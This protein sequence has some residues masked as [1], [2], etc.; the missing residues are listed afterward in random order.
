MTGIKDIDLN[1][2][3]MISD[4]VI[5]H[6]ESKPYHS[7]CVNCAAVRDN[8]ASARDKCPLI[9]PNSVTVNAFQSLVYHQPKLREMAEGTFLFH[10]VPEDLFPLLGEEDKYKAYLHEVKNKTDE[11]MVEYEKILDGLKTKGENPFFRRRYEFLN[12]LVGEES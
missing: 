7:D 12:Y 4:A 10:N 1:E 2:I 11:D 3:Y 5:N 9:P 6:D 8:G